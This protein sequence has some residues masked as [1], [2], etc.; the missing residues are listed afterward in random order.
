MTQHH[1]LFFKETFSYSE[2]VIDFLKATL[3]PELA[4][5]I[6]YSSIV[7]EKDT[8][9]DSDLSACFSDMVYSCRLKGE[10]IRLAFLFE[11]KSSTTDIVVN[12]DSN[13]KFHF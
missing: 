13:K 6:D 2:H 7:S 11:H 3:P 8:Y 10:Q 4:Q 12:Q 9:V 1:D 5:G